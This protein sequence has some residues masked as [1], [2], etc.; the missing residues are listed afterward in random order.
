MCTTLSSLVM[1]LKRDPI[2]EDVPYCT[3]K[4]FPAIID[5]CIEWARDKVAPSA[6]VHMYIYSSFWPTV[7][8]VMPLARCVV[9][10]SVVCDILYCGKL[11]RPSEKVSEEVNRKPGSKSS[12]FGSPP[13]F[14]FRFRRYGHRD[15][16]FC[17]MYC[18][19]TVRFS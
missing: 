11:V 14:Y 8:L 7:L 13:Y 4:S 18:G 17:L 9:C 16:R 6:H 5:H 19:K 2:D 3:L 12:F 15:G 10:L 1:L